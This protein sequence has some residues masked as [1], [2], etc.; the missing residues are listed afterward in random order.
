MVGNVREDHHF[1]R[2]NRYQVLS[3][4]CSIVR[5]S[6]DM[7]HIKKRDKSQHPTSNLSMI[8]RPL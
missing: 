6:F 7:P 4:N 8:T 1:Y 5:C 2:V 3:N